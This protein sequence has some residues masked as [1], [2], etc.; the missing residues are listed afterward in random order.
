MKLIIQH[1]VADYATWEPAFAAHEETRAS[2]CI[3]NPR[4]YRA[5][6]DPNDVLAVFDVEDYDAAE[7]LV[8]SD[9]MA[10][11]MKSAGVTGEP[12]VHFIDEDD[13]FEEIA[14]EDEPE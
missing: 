11:T 6:D 3:I 5:V 1:K 4:V 8:S 10:E 9:E 7:E 12:T 14:S 13:D 2:A